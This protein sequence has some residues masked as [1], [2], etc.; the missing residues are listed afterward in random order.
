MVK[1][2]II[3]SWLGATFFAY[4]WVMAVGSL[5][6]EGKSWP[7]ALLNENKMV[8]FGATGIFTMLCLLLYS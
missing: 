5:R 7:D 3:I 4:L 2:A 8:F 6:D 1:W